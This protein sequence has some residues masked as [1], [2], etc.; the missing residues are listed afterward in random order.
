MSIDTS[1]AAPDFSPFPIRRL[2]I[3]EYHRLAESGVL[4]END[5]VEL[6]EGLLVQKMIHNPAH[7]GTIDIADELLRHMLPEG[8]RLRIQSS[9]AAAWF[10]FCSVS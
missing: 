9:K 5:R 10:A 1:H 7:D 3:D 6:L 4:S 8:W 2:S